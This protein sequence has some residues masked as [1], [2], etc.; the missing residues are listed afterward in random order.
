MVTVRPAKESDAQA[1]VGVMRRSITQLCHLDHKGDADVIARWLANKTPEVFRAWLAAPD[2][3]LVV[4]EGA[5]GA[6]LGVGGV[7]GDGRIQLNYVDPDARFSGVSKAL[8]ASMEQILLL[9]GHSVARLT[10]TATAHRFYAAQGY[11]DDGER[12]P[13]IARIKGQPMVKELRSVQDA[14]IAD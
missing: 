8:L 4:A 14:G 6:V 9:A 10:S 3:Q 13:A 5:D 11:R 1:A 7:N 12:H 2:N